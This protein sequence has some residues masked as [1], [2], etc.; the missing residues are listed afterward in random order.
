M[1]GTIDSV[2]NRYITEN[3]NYD[4]SKLLKTKHIYKINKFNTFSICCRAKNA[5]SLIPALKFNFH[6][7]KPEKKNETRTYYTNKEARDQDF[8]YR[9]LLQHKI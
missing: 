3:N 4:E 5:M 6:K 9:I 1:N 2:V 7:I 8:S